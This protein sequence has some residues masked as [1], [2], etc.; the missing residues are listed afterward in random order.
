MLREEGRSQGRE[1]LSWNLEEA[2]CASWV[3][4]FQA[5]QQGHQAKR[6]DKTP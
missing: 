4:W 6:G 3:R 5:E 1:N 2:G